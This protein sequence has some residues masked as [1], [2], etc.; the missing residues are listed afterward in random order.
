M[1]VPEPSEMQPI[2]SP[3][4]T[5]PPCRRTRGKIKRGPPLYELLT[6]RPSSA[7]R[8]RWRALLSRL[9]PIFKLLPAAHL[10]TLLALERYNL[11]QFF[12]LE[13]DG[14][15]LMFVRITAEGMAARDRW[16]SL[17]MY[18]LDRQ[19]RLQ[20]GVPMAKP[21]GRPPGKSQKLAVATPSLDKLSELRGNNP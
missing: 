5:S 11:I 1:S 7:T 20:L 6:S 8:R 19:V 14:K 17:Q 16:I 12:P 21:R 2:L 4:E 15:R 18:A 3:E 10:S 13:I 9:G